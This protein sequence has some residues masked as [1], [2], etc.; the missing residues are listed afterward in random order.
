[1]AGYLP[2]LVSRR[3]RRD[4]DLSEHA[5]SDAITAAH[6]QAALLAG[7]R[8]FSGAIRLL[9]GRRR[10]ASGPARRST[11]QLGLLLTRSGRTDEAIQEFRH[12]A[13]LRPDA[14]DVPLALA[15]AL[16]HVG[17]TADAAAAG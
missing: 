2:G 7:D 5:T 14:I 11:I 9:A 13:D 12:A 17:R 1:M 4:E 10:A 6:H 15:D 8:K 3:A 16:L